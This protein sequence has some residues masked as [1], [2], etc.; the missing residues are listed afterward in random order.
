[1]SIRGQ[2][3]LDLAIFRKFFSIATDTH[4]YT[5]MKN[6]NA[7]I[8]R[9]GISCEHFSALVRRLTKSRLTAI[10]SFVDPARQDRAAADSGHL[11]DWI[12]GGHSSSGSVGRT[13]QPGANQCRNADLRSKGIQPQLLVQFIGQKDSGSPHAANIAY[14]ATAS[15]RLPETNRAGNLAKRT[16]G[17]FFSRPDLS[18]TGRWA[19]E[20]G[21][22]P[23]AMARARE[24]YGRLSDR[25]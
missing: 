7:Q 17:E 25:R 3:V 24:S 11:Q 16:P 5:R 15:F 20:P 18:E 13:P 2:Q 23:S 19:T 6:L 12:L 4:G 22:P 21:G 8:L 10:Q 1:M 14:T 9:A